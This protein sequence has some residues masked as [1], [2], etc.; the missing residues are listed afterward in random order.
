M[1]RQ[2]DK[3]WLTWDKGIVDELDS[4]FMNYVKNLLK[5]SP[6]GYF[7]KI[8]DQKLRFTFGDVPSIHTVR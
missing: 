5:L 7:R 8:D 6:A 1:E 3:N 4:T 2:N